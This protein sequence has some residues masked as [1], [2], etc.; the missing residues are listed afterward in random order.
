MR[1]QC[2]QVWLLPLQN[3][4]KLRALVP[5]KTTPKMHLLYPV[6]NSLA[7]ELFQMHAANLPRVEKHLSIVESN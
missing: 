3:P 2:F 4:R 1:G 7:T 5:T 6:E